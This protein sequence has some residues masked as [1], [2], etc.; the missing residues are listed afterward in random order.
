MI[1]P[2]AARRALWAAAL[3]LGLGG[4]LAWTTPAPGQEVQ[5][6]G[7]K[8]VVG[9]F[10]VQGPA[11]PGPEM[12]A[13]LKDYVDHL[14]RKVYVKPEDLYVP[15]LEGAEGFS[16]DQVTPQEA[17]PV[18][19]GNV[20]A[21]TGEIEGLAIGQ[22][23]G[24]I[25][26]WS[27]YPRRK[28]RMPGGRRPHALAWAQSSPLL[29]ALD[30]SRQA[31]Y[32]F[33]LRTQG[34]ALQVRTGHQGEITRAAMSEGGAWLAFTDSGGGLFAG[35]PGGP[36]QPVP[37]LG[38]PPVMIG[39]T[40]AQGLLVSADG[41]GHAVGYALMNHQ[42][43]REMDVPG[44]PFIDGFVSGQALNLV[45]R[46]GTTVA[47][48]LLK[49]GPADASER[50]G[51]R[52]FIRDGK[53]HYTTGLT[54]WLKTTRMRRPE[55]ILS[56]SQRLGLVRLRDLDGQTRYYSARTGEPDLAAASAAPEN[57]DWVLLDGVNGQYRFGEQGFQLYDQVFQSGFQR[58]FSRYIPG[59][60]FFLWWRSTEKP[61]QFNPRPMHLPVRR[62]VLAGPEPEWKNLYEG[63]LP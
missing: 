37:G 4:P 57:G 42:I 44:G 61:A 1:R 28:A 8:T 19:A 25:Y 51:G 17:V 49:P 31:L 9:E 13:S 3:A 60:G 23:N 34:P 32:L 14:L 10:Y 2:S 47:W 27:A 33:D 56:L 22:D 53:V 5:P 46:D 7:R 36:F 52:L 24:D 54:R 55:L 43:L 11:T 41:R 39:F 6:D 18:L 48:S 30:Q 12:V 63:G 50:G 59:K 35:P 38:G 58:L 26:I 15:P 62:T 29:A 20:A 45:A 16:Y 40:P 21:M